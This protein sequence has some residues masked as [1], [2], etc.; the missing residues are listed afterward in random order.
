MIFR[1]I[2]KYIRNPYKRVSFLIAQVANL[3]MSTYLEKIFCMA[4]L[5][6]I[7]FIKK[8]FKQN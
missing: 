1:N 2:E 5:N 3:T 4:L 6:S 7:Q 8:Y